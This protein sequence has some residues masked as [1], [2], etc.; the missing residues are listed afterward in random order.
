M[1]KL[2]YLEGLDLYD[3]KLTGEIPPELGDLENLQEPYLHYN[4]L[5]GAVPESPGRL[6]RMKKLHHTGELRG[7]LDDWPDPGSSLQ[8]AR[9]ALP[10]PGFEVV[11]STGIPDSSDW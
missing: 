6:A 11:V 1:G 4:N 5:S 7:V 9:R 3:N 8:A 2:A 10:E